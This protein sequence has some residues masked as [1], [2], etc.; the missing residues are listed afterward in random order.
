MKGT[1]RNL[2]DGP[3]RFASLWA[4]VLCCLAL[5]AEAG[6]HTWVVN[7][8][9]TN[10]DGTVQFVELA[11]GPTANET[12]L[13]GKNVT[14]SALGVVHT[15]A[16]NLAAGSTANKK[17]LLATAAFVALPGA[18][19]PDHIIDSN[20]FSISGDTL[21]WHV[22][23]AS[24]LTWTAGQLPTD[25][26]NSWNRGGTSAANSPTNFAGATG[27]VDASGPPAVPDGGVGA[28][29]RGARL[30][31]LGSS[32]EVSWDTATCSGAAD[33]IL[34]YGDRSQLPQAAG[35][36]FAPAGAICGLGASSP[37]TWNNPPEAGDAS[38]LIWWL[39][40]VQNGTVEG[41][42]GTDSGGAERQGPGAGGASAL[43]GTASKSTA[44]SCGQ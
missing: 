22:Y 44:N 40:V 6:S 38:G 24:I 28:P 23:A 11:N 15:F 25:G 2:P 36:A 42:W 41:S 20:S 16:S 31:D 30:D 12:G 9:F 39:V 17:I 7:E 37:F 32:I 18:P 26:V 5:P 29:V 27:S 8:V 43:C 34:L 4:A 33:H 21:Q 3:S 14:S 13:A 35:G 19:A 1:M 10:A